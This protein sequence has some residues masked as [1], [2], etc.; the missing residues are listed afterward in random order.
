MILVAGRAAL[1]VGAHPRQPLIGVRPVELELDVLVEQ[2]EA[3]LASD[4]GLAGPEQSVQEL[5]QDRSP[6]SSS[7]AR[8]LRRASCNV[9]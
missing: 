3:L 6:S 4:L 9:L 8:S 2:F 5:A 7:S 1:E